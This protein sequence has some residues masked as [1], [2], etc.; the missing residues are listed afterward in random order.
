MLE[1]LNV[2]LTQAKSV[3][4]GFQD[5]VKVPGGLY[6]DLF[7]LVMVVRLLAVLKGFPPVSAAEAA[8]WGT[9][10]GSLAYSNG[11]PKSS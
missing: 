4:A 2:F 5:L 1:K 10:V 8:V 9:T 7:G 6:V 3:F 11:G